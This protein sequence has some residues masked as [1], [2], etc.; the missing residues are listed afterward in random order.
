MNESF[1]TFHLNLLRGLGVETVL[2]QD[3]ALVSMHG[4]ELEL[5]FHL[6]QQQTKI[7]SSKGPSGSCP[8]RSSIGRSTT[9]RNC[10]VISRTEDFYEG[11]LV[12][13]GATSQWRFWPKLELCEVLLLIVVGGALLE[14]FYN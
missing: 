1:G 5:S 12:R 8:L 11:V 2:E 13:L 7:S 14:T 6:K 4:G 9:V 3:L 10:V